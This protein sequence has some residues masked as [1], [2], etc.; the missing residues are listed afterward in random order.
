MFLPKAERRPWVSVSTSAVLHTALIILAI[1]LT[2]HENELIEEQQAEQRSAEQREHVVPFFLPPPPPPKPVKPPQP[3]PPQPPPRPQPKVETPP[4]TPVP[5]APP[6][7]AEQRKPEPEPNAPPDEKRSVGTAEPEDK[8]KGAKAPDDAARSRAP[9]ADIAMTAM[10]S[11]AKRIFGR[12]KEGPPAGAGPRDVRPL[13]TYLP[14]RPDKCT[15]K[16]V[17]PAESAGAP[18]MGVAVGRIFRGDNGR[19]L[20]GAHLVM[21]G[22]PYTSFTDDQGEY[23]FRFDLSLVDNCRTQYVRVSAQGY[24]SRLLVL[25]VGPRTRSEDVMLRRRR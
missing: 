23:T 14:D 20:A 21:L 4:P 19:P 5:V 18:Q 15:P 10:E 13:E 25:V 7:Q 17:A 22:T 16:P 12:K 6:P 11:E 3:P 24:E 2:R 8:N 9:P 1:L